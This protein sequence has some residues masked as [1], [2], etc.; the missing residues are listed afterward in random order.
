M[1]QKGNWV[2]D[3]H[4]GMAA[5]AVPEQEIT[6]TLEKNRIPWQIWER[7]VTIVQMVPSRTIGPDRDT[8]RETKISRRDRAVAIGHLVEKRVGS[9]RTRGGPRSAGGGSAQGPACA[10]HPHDQA[11]GLVHGHQSPNRERQDTHVA[12]HVLV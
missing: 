5:R 8:I 11:I 6:E 3:F 9:P 2:A 1:H 10:E 4:A 7:L 12:P